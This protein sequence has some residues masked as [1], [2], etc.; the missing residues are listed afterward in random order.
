MFDLDL[1]DCF[2]V[3]E[4]ED[5]LSIEEKEQ[6]ATRASQ[7]KTGI[8]DRTRHLLSEAKKKVGLLEA[9]R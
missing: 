4:E 1:G 8:S 5:P 6:L 2:A 7:L 3:S 9:E